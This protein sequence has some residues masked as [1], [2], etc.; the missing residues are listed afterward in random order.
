MK[1]LNQ[2]AIKYPETK[3]K[4]VLETIHGQKIVDEY[5]WLE[6]IENQEV[7]D[8][9]KQQNDHTSK[10]LD[11][12]PHREKF[13][14]RLEELLR[15]E[16][17]LLPKEADSGWFFRKRRPNDQ[18]PILFFRPKEDPSHEIELI[19]VNKL[20]PSGLT[21]IDFWEPSSDGKFLAYG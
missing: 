1:D 21:S 19:N 11:Q 17:V 2:E 3:I 4:S 14:K 7:K 8:W 20:D 12:L 16:D 9:L 15:I 10:I 6:L 5:R 13:K 18:Q